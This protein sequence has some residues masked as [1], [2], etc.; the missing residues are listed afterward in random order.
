M[1]VSNISVSAPTS[2]MVTPPVVPIIVGSSISLPCTVELSPLVDVPVTVNTVWTGPDG[3][4]T[5]NTAQPVSGNTTTTYASTATVS[6]S[7]RE[8][9]GNYSC[10]ATVR[11]MLPSII[12]SVGYSSSRVIV[13]KAINL[14]D[15]RHAVII[16]LCICHP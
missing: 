14:N 6:S 16:D 10:R 13:G 15:Y 2:V 5:T 1:C 11:A 12:D 8:Q 3:V 9:S 7:G 4:M